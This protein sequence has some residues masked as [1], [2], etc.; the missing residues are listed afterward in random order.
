[1]LASG[2]TLRRAL[3]H[4]KGC[5]SCASVSGYLSSSYSI[6]GSRAQRSARTCPLVGT[7]NRQGAAVISRTFGSS[8]SQETGRGRLRRTS[9]VR[10]MGRLPCKLRS[11]PSPGNDC[12]ARASSKGRTE[13]SEP[14]RTT[15]KW[16]NSNPSASAAHARARVLHSDSGCMSGFCPCPDLVRGSPP[17]G[18]GWV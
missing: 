7:V 1:M 6:H 2:S 5:C 11:S 18:A 12:G 10:T 17:H 15:R 3:T 14:D 9:R 4:F 16:T 13:S 8:T